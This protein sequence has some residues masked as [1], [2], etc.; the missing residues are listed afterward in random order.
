MPALRPQHCQP[1]QKQPSANVHL[2]VWTRPAFPILGDATG[3]SEHPNE[4]LD[5]RKRPILSDVNPE[6]LPFEPGRGER[7]V[8]EN[9]VLLCQVSESQV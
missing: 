6:S 8:P 5:G 4:G 3:T 9:Q 7:A 1:S 2:G